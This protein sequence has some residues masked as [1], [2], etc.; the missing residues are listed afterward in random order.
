MASP[1]GILSNKAVPT[2]Y[3]V[4]LEP[5]IHTNKLT[6]SVDIKLQA[7][8]E[9]RMLHLNSVDLRIKN[10]VLHDNIARL[11]S[12]DSKKIKWRQILVL[13]FDQPISSRKEFIVRI[14]FDGTISKGVAGF[15]ST[16]YKYFE[17]I[18]HKF[19]VTHM[20]PSYCRRVFPCFDEPALKASF[21]IEV[22]LPSVLAVLSNMSVEKKTT[23]PNGKIQTTF[24]KTPKMSTYQLVVIAIGGFDSIQSTE[25]TRVPIKLYAPLGQA[26]QGKFALDLAAKST[27][28]FE[29]MFG[30]AYPLPKLDLVAIPNFEIGATENWG[31]IIY[32]SSDLLA[33]TKVKGKREI[34]KAMLHEVAQQWFG[35]LVTMEFWDSIW[36]KEGFATWISWFAIHHFFPEW[37]IWRDHVA[38]TLQTALELDALRSSHPVETP[39][40]DISMYQAF[41]DISYNKGFCILRMISKALGEDNALQ[42]VSKVE[43]LKNIS[44]WT[45]Q[46]GFP[47]VFV[48]EVVEA[49]HLLIKLTQR[50]YL[51]DDSQNESKDSYEIWPISVMLKTRSGIQN[52][53]FTTRNISFTIDDPSFFKINVD[54][55]GFYRTAY[56]NKRLQ[57]FALAAKEGLLSVEDRIGLFTDAF[58][59]SVSG[60]QDTTA[61]LDF[62][63][64]M[65]EEPEFLVWHRISVVLRDLRYAF[66]FKD[67]EIQ[68]GLMKFSCHMVDSKLREIGFEIEPDDDED[69]QNLK[70]LI[71]EAAVFS[72]IQSVI[73]NAKSMFKSYCRGHTEALHPALRNV[74]YVLALANGVDSYHDDLKELYDKSS[75]EAE[76]SRIQGYLYCIAAE[77]GLQRTLTSAFGSLV[78]NRD[79]LL[80][81]WCLSNSADGTW[82]L[83]DWANEYWEDIVSKNPRNLSLIIQ[84][85][86]DGFST[87]YQVSMVQKFFGERETRGY[88]QYANQAIELL[89]IRNRWVKRDTDRIAEWLKRHA[90]IA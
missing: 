27:R 34:A 90:F 14:A 13:R 16:E 12:S 77:S 46:V 63:L 26:S 51:P 50:R 31:L 76:K 70:Q 39:I 30:C 11:S 4:H 89:R 42:E 81:I 73:S 35:N 2:D 58:A 67:D 61:L 5:D 71:Y 41:D 24:K 62:L 25:R 1:H 17:D 82:E 47:V 6:G 55:V 53:D 43:T 44:A 87:D 3:T 8:S 38:F 9:V 37:C 33:D 22:V 20:E 52:H 72:G 88:D 28:F 80:T 49:D 79:L 65:R 66:R 32:R 40:H 48:E 15:Y 7:L 75:S 64:E 83:W 86:V 18:Q 59:L 21:S 10:A 84:A 69:T 68:A 78:Q 85:L 57:T 29:K 36:L 74:T 23:L 45:R 60:H 19:L 54:H 56:S